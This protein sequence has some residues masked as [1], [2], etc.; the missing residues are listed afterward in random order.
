MR[1]TALDTG[2]RPAR[3]KRLV[4]PEKAAIL[5][6]CLGEKRG[7]DL[8]QKLDEDEIQKITRAMARLGMIEGSVVEQVMTEFTETV[9]NG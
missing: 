3:R 5:F 7:S 4:G 9:Y 8:M 6:L 2:E 1:R